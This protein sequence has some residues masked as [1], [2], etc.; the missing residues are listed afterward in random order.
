MTY[1]FIYRL[2]ADTGLAPCVDDGMLSLAVCKG[3][4]I[5]N[6]KIVNTG[7]R[8]NI[9]SGNSGADYKKDNIYILGTFKN[10]FLYLARITDII[11]MTEYFKVMSSGRIDDIYD[12]E[13]GELIRNSLFSKEEIHTEPERIEKDKAGQYVLLSEDYIYL[14][15]EAEHV[16][17][18]DKYNA[19]F[20]E[21]KKYTG[22]VAEEII[23]EC[24]KYKDG[25]KH[26][27]HDPLKRGRCK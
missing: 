7:L 9:G 15:K 4:Q 1:L 17:I 23:S 16:E 10:K 12:V 22:E 24:M 18:L 2:T 21:T 3:G 8:Y 6:G 14:G 26:V 19:R 20:Q 27:P 5:R 13:N 11:T 25:K